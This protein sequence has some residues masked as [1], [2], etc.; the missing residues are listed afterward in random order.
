MNAK[1]NYSLKFD[2]IKFKS[3]KNLMLEAEYFM[4]TPRN[5]R[6]SHRNPGTVEK[7][8]SVRNTFVT[9]TKNKSSESKILNDLN[10]EQSRYSLF[11]HVL[12][13][14]NPKLYQ[15]VSCLDLL[16]TVYVCKRH[17]IN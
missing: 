16:L 12:N 4:Q 5:L 17:G 10:P 2:I 15:F 6:N 13:S 7:R 1:P 8:V 3:S 9:F 11:I 14:V